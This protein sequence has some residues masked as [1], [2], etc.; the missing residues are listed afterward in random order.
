MLDEA[1]RSELTR[2][3]SPLKLETP[4]KREATPAKQPPGTA[5]REPRADENLE[6][7]FRDLPEEPAQAQ[8][9]PGE[10]LAPVKQEEEPK[11]MEIEPPAKPKEEVALEEPEIKYK[12]RDP[13][14]GR[15]FNTIEEFK[16]LRTLHSQNEQKKVK[17][18]VKFYQTLKEK[19]A[20]I[21]E[22]LVVK[23]K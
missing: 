22:G 8:Q 12:Y 15:G 9:A 10:A 14:T 16:K 20:E 18:L 2:K 7:P 1:V 23:D 6:N 17:Q 19:K 3:E 13:K 5:E 11:P 4:V 21:L